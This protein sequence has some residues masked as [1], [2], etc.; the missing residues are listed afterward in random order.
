[1]VYHFT[2]DTKGWGGFYTDPNQRVVELHLLLNEYPI[3][4]K[5]NSERD[6]ESELIITMEKEDPK[7]KEEI[8][9]AINQRFVERHI[10][11]PRRTD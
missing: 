5:P 3:E 8:M 6:H 4:V 10:P 11:I 1:M 2:V 7:M 9:R